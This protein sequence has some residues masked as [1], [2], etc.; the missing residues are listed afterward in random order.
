MIDDY[1]ERVIEFE[2]ARNEA[3]D[4]YFDARPHLER[5]RLQEMIFEGGFRAAWAKTVEVHNK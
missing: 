1:E 5:T 4:K 3:M 2:S